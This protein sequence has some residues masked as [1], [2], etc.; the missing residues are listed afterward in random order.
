M[1]YKLVINVCPELTIKSSPTE[2]HQFPRLKQRI[3]AIIL[4]QYG[5][6]RKLGWGTKILF[7]SFSVNLISKK[8]YQNAL[9]PSGFFLVFFYYYCFFYSGKY[10][11]TDQSV[12]VWFS[13]AKKRNEKYGLVSPALSESRHYWLWFVLVPTGLLG[14]EGIDLNDGL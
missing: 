5:R 2:G 9:N 11:H 7:V 6:Y 13:D 3:W 8:I 12:I 14:H 4:W 10:G 1:I